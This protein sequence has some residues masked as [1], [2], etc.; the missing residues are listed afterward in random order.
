MSSS[1]TK[2]QVFLSRLGSTLGLW[3]VVL[4]ALFAPNQSIAN[5]AFLLILILLG[6]FGFREY[7]NMVRKTGTQILGWPAMVAGVALLSLEVSNGWMAE[8]QL[9]EAKSTLIES[10]LENG[11]DDTIYLHDTHYITVNQGFTTNLGAPLIATLLFLWLTT[12]KLR[13][14]GEIKL[15]SLAA[16]FFGWFYVFWLLSFIGKI[17]YLPTVQGTWFLLYFILVTKFSDLGA[18]L[19]GSLIG[20]HKMAPKISPGKTW[21]GFGGAIV[22]STLVSVITIYA[23]GPSLAP[24]KGAHAII[25]GVLLSGLAVVGDLV[26]SLMKRETGVKDSGTL[27]PGIGGALD[28]IDSLLFNAP[29]FYIYCRLTLAT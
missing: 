16:T 19:V 22:V 10:Q 3:T 15:N 11:S 9:A 1:P 26:E 29:I 2:A 6:V 27:F 17:Y 18:Y 24:L 28:L 4:L 13:S 12:L 21:E 7:A 20:K 8:K 14:S 25:L 5:S 23:A